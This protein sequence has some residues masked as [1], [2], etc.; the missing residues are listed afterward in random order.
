MTRARVLQLW[1]AGKLVTGLTA[2]AA[3]VLLVVGEL[4][5][6]RHGVTVQGVVGRV[7]KVPAGF[8]E[9]DTAGTTPRYVYRVS[10]HYE[11]A[12]GNGH[13][14]EVATSWNRYREGQEVSVQYPEDA[15]DRSRIV[16]RSS[17]WLWPGAVL[18]FIVGCGLAAVN[19]WELVRGTSRDPAGGG[20]A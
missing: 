9:S 20:R 19:G 16:T 11:D 4:E 12:A 5:Y 15:P 6:V 7:E 8:S 3:A 13:A 14:G 1:T 10:Y 2:I 18:L 17:L